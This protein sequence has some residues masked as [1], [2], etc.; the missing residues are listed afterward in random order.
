M[1]L[2]KFIYELEQHFLV[3]VGA[4]TRLD[5]ESYHPV[6]LEKPSHSKLT[7]SIGLHSLGITWYVSGAELDT[8][9]RTELILA[10]VIPSIEKYT[11]S[12]SLI[13]NPL[14]RIHISGIIVIIR[15]Y[16]RNSSEPPLI[17]MPSEKI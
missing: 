6:R 17:E 10:E 2:N 3:A 16:S 14:T 11:E 12:E 9:I 5:L 1:L 7:A 15:T 4:D 13:I 8:D